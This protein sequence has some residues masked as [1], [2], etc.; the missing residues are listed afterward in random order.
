MTN[1]RTI[2]ILGFGISF[3]FPV[4][5]KIETISLAN[6]KK[7]IPGGLPIVTAEG[8]LP[9]DPWTEEV[10]DAYRALESLKKN[11]SVSS[12]D[13][14]AAEYLLIKKKAEMPQR[15]QF[16]PADS[17]SVLGNQLLALD[18]AVAL[19]FNPPFIE[20]GYVPDNF[21]QRCNVWMAK[22]NQENNL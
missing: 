18:N 7:P 2:L 22:I 15:C 19:H 20:P 5:A 21:N 1:C 10:V 9:L 4:L 14:R 8:V 11:K 17:I 16:L 6:T 13:L 12:E 3:C